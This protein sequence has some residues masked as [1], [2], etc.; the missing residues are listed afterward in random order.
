M[1][2]NSMQCCKIRSLIVKQ[3]QPSLHL[4]TKTSK[5]KENWIIKDSESFLKFQSRCQ[6]RYLILK[7]IWKDFI[8]LKYG[9]KISSSSKGL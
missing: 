9:D 3:P 6:F 5:V 4:E 7:I 1:L 2:G 8:I